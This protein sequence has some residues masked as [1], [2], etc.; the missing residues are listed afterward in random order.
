MRISSIETFL[1]EA[2]IQPGF[3][4]SQG[5][6]D[7][8]HVGLVKLVTDDGIVGW[9][10]GLYGPSARIVH[11]EFAPLLLGAT[12][13]AQTLW[14]K[15]F[16]LF[17]NGNVPGGI[18]AAPSAPSTPL[19]D[20]RR[21]SQRPAVPTL[22][23]AK[24]ATHRRQRHRPYYREALPSDGRGLRNGCSTRPACMLSLASPA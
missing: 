6:T 15:M 12:N 20:N 11:E 10:E 5:W 13:A 3:G 24:S 14:Q 19:W 17:Y 16:R 8:R 1:L 22:L 7:K 21:Q 23:G 4:W 9:G 2:P 18:A